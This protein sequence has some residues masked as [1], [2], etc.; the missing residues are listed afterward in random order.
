MLFI[1]NKM[2]QQSEMNEKDQKNTS[3]GCLFRIVKP[4]TFS[5]QVSSCGHANND[6]CF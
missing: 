6:F 1:S 3:I 2:H 5:W 4:T